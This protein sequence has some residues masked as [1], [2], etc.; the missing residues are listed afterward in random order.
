MISLRVQLNS[1]IKKE[2]G[3]DNLYE[4]VDLFQID[5]IWTGCNDLPENKTQNNV[6]TASVSNYKN[7]I[8][9]LE[10]EDA[11][12]LYSDAMQPTLFDSPAITNP[13]PRIWI[14]APGEQARL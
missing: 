7:F 10:T 9:F 8:N 3:K 12:T 11:V 1:I 13:N 6:Y 14:Y 2:S 4:V 5:K